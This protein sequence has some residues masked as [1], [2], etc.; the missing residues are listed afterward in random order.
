MQDYWG[1]KG[2]KCVVTGGSSGMG[3]AAAEM[4]VDLGAEVY[5]LDV[6]RV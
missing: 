5:G 2:K 1:Y 6:R 3:R 4:L